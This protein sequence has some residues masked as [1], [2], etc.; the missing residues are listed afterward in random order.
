M[1]DIASRLKKARQ[2]VGKTPRQVAREVGLNL[3]SYR[4]LEFGHDWSHGVSLGEICTIAKAVGLTFSELM[5][6]E[7]QPKD[8]LISATDLQTQLK[9]AVKHS[10]TN[11]A[12]FE[13]QLGWGISSFL[14]DSHDVK[15][16]NIDC[17][18]AVC[19]RL[20][21]DWRTFQLMKI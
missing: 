16:W 7:D 8:Q 9:A 15:N 17:L 3:P 18:R 10:G 12:E 11:I 19:G 1:A 5:S 13:K 21:V 14:T 6:A 2:K 4:D 20:G